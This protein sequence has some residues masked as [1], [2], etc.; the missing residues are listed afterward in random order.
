[1]FLSPFHEKYETKN[2]EINAVLLL[3]REFDL[4]Y[5]NVI[6]CNG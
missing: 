5:L 3:Q 2:H 6:K 4:V 1:M